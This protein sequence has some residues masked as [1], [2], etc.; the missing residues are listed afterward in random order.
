MI[1]TKIE[2]F[3]SAG[4][5]SYALSHSSLVRVD[6][7][8]GQVDHLQTNDFG[9]VDP[10]SLFKRQEIGRRRLAG[11]LEGKQILE[12]GSGDGRNFR[13]AGYSGSIIT[14]VEIEGWRNEL[15][16]HNLVGIEKRP[17]EKVKLWTGD[18]SAYLRMRS[19]SVV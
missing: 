2:R 15:A 16:R 19:E 10:W 1:D 4:L 5:S 14:G 17:E 3:K 6:F 12:F 13:E 8:V 11:V 18:A 9:V 7:G